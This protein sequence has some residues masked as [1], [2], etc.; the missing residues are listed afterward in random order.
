MPLSAKC[1][2]QS[3]IETFHVAVRKCIKLFR[4]R[5]SPLWINWHPKLNLS[6]QISFLLVLPPRIM[7]FG[8]SKP[9]EERHSH[10]VTPKF[11]KCATPSISQKLIY[12]ITERIILLPGSIIFLMT[13]HL[14]NLSCC[15]V[16]D[17][18]I[19]TKWTSLYRI[20]S[21]TQT[22]D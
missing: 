16:H 18:I 1:V 17:W 11:Y 13:Y 8:A 4:Q 15:S 10:H 19:I 20:P 21:H 6:L 12:E 22:I 3:L 2:T 14:V 7:I 9:Q 5:T